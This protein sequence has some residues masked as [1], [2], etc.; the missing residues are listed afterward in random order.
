MKVVDPHMHL[1]NFHRIHYPWLEKPQQ[2]W[3][4]GPY[5]TLAKDFFL[6]D[7]LKLSGG[8]EVVK[9]VHI[10]NGSAATD[11]LA[12]SRWL[13]SIADDPK[14]GGLPNGVV[15]GID[16]SDADVEKHLSL[17]AELDVVRGI[18]Q[19]LNIHE[20]PFYD[21]VGHNFLRDEAWRAGFA[22]LKRFNFSFD[23]QLYPTQMAEA[24]NLAGEHLET[25]LIVNHTGM[26]VDR[27]TVSGWR[28]W[29]DGMRRLAAHENVAV[30]I[31]GLGMIDH[32]WTVESIRP[33]VL[34]TIDCFGIERCMFA[35]NSPVDGLYGTY[36]AL[37]QA[38]EKCIEGLSEVEKEKLF[39]SNAERLYR[40]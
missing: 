10:E 21:F 18:R 38:Y 34:E 3:L 31:S 1:C 5:D 29:R 23:L 28:L 6:Q 15:A 37:W 16:L 27:D 19:I 20:N 8:V 25:V 24:A 40:I 30:K 35:S 7:F 33:Y 32:S 26:F 12:E 39:R 36:S 14:S 22:L 11:R 4:I 17:Q 2:D 13:Q 9:I